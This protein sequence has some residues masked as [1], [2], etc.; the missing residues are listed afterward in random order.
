MVL[1][2]VVEQGG[3]KQLVN[4]LDPRY[5]VPGRKYFSETALPNLYDS[6]RQTLM[7]ELQKVPHCN[8]DGVAGLLLATRHLSGFPWGPPTQDMGR[9][10]RCLL[11]SR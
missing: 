5:T 10:S 4:M 1:I 6:C 2:Q 7:N 9:C 11:E 3:F 8:N